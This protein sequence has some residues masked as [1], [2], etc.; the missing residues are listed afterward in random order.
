MGDFHGSLCLQILKLGSN[1]KVHK[2]VCVL[3]DK[4]KPQTITR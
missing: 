3:H 1:S 2:K 4:D